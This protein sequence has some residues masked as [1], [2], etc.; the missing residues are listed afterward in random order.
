M[1]NFI[2]S[3]LKVVIFIMFTCILSIMSGC[4]QKGPLYLPDSN[5]KKAK[6]TLETQEK[7]Q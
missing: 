7:S 3:S 6:Q 2:N 4:G 1:Q 5:T